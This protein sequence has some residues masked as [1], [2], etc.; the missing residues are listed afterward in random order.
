MD[1]HNTCVQRWS[2]REKVG[3]ELRPPTLWSWS[4]LSWGWGEALFRLRRL[5]LLSTCLPRLIPDPP[6]V[7]GSEQY[8][9]PFPSLR[10][11]PA[12]Q[13]CGGPRGLSLA[14]LGI[15]QTSCTPATHPA[16]ILAWVHSGI[17]KGKDP[18]LAGAGSTREQCWEALVPAP[19][20]KIIRQKEHCFQGKGC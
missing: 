1:L 6:Y 13:D 4:E 18:P 19:H 9:Y 7:H 17:L 5:C 3:Y 8:M 10:C 11:S 12:T 14:Y 16:Y 15:G 2:A 20:N